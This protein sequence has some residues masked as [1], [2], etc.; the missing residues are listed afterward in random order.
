[1][2]IFFAN[3]RKYQGNPWNRSAATA[4]LLL[5]TLVTN[6]LNNNKI[7][8]YKIKQFHVNT[9]WFQWLLSI[10]SSKHLAIQKLW[11]FFYLQR[12]NRSWTMS[13]AAK[14]RVLV[15]GAQF[16]SVEKSGVLPSQE[17]KSFWKRNTNKLPGRYSVS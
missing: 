9:Q 4:A 6:V 11:I 12:Y 8:H 7:Y 15:L 14:N 10:R 17:K 2:K 3:I 13:D 16:N 1:M 5:K